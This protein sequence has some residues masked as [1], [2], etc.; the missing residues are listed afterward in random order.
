MRISKTPFNKIN[1]LA[2]KDIYYQ[3]QYQHLKSFYQYEPTFDG[4][5]AAIEGRK[6]FPV[7]RALLSEVLQDQYKNIDKSASQDLNI[8]A[9]KDDKTFT[10][11]TAHQ[12]SLLG[13]P[14]YYF[15]KMFSIINLT[16]KLNQELP[17]YKFIPVFINGSEDHDFDE[18]KT[19]N[20]FGKS[21]TWDT[22][23]S[24][25]V[26]RFSTE[27]LDTA[28]E[29]L[30]SILGKS[31][32][33]EQIGEI[34]KDAFS[35][36]NNYNDFVAHWVNA[37]FKD[38]G[39]LVLNMDDKRLKAAF[40]P[41]MEREITERISLPLVTATQEA[42]EKE[43]KFTPQ[44]FVRDINL[45]YINNHSRERIY[46][47]DDRFKINNSDLSFTKEEILNLLHEHPERF[48][49]NVVLRPMYEEFT[50]PNL[51]YIGGGGELAYWLER[52]SQFAAFN[53]FY[54]VL[55]RRNSVMFI[56][57]HLQKLMEK[58]GISED[59]LRKEENQLINEYIDKNTEE[60]FYLTNESKQIMQ[61]FYEIA[62]KAKHIDATL[63]PTVLGEAHKTIKT[64]EN[65]E[66][67]LKRSIKQKQEVQINQIK[68]L[69]S[70]LF[71]EN[72][73]QERVESYLQFWT[74]DVYDLNQ[75]MVENL[76]PL[77]KDFLTIYL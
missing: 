11:V 2:Y 15:Y 28:I 66:N 62:D 12:P 76:N 31:P 27:N 21:I 25:S 18:I 41:V 63:E 6:N 8:Q 74:N 57:K 67:R 9:L 34:F 42:L 77:D 39:L 49:P 46:F 56:P 24:G 68:N 44:A 16:S 37:F 69:K 60:E 36:A 33:A 30:I 19:I 29:A 47:E 26:G 73:L 7:E 1:K 54:P 50:L 13:G 23:Q 40:I 17:D 43:H 48:S 70:K 75:I 14:G 72:N 5:K 3:E 53:V 38:Y 10:I 64:V 51:A 22:P 59:D 32:K 35:K 4:I 61:A 45:F 58:L 20:L 65:L 55:I 52:K 71:P